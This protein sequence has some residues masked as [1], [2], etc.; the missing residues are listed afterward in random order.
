MFPNPSTPK[1]EVLARAY[2][3]Y[4]QQLYSFSNPHKMS[5]GDNSEIGSS[6]CRSLEFKLGCLHARFNP[7]VTFASAIIVWG[8]VIFCLVWTDI[9]SDEIPKWQAW[10]TTTWTWLYI[11]TQDVWFAFIVVLYFSKYSNIKLG[12][13]DEK[14]EFSDGSYFAMLF[15]AGIGVGLFYFGVAEPVYHY[16]PGEYGNRYWGR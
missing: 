11:G 2:I 16:S 1:I 7:V 9:A 10:V 4:A 15:A 12:K 3:Y 5:D 13:Q 6:K 14:P 8:F